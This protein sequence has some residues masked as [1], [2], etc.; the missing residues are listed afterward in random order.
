MENLINSLTVLNETK[1]FSITVFA[2]KIYA[3]LRS[4][5]YP[6]LWGFA[7]SDHTPSI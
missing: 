3:S 7:Y 5:N 6:K 4:L 2:S 1:N